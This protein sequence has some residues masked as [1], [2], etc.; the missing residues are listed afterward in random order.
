MSKTQDAVR[1]I[2]IWVGIASVLGCATSSE[3]KE[4]TKTERA[5]LF[6]DVA[7]ASLM[8]GDAIAALENLSRAESFAP[9]MPEI[10]HS[11]ALAFHMKKDSEAAIAAAKKAVEMSPKYS[12]AN[13]TLGKLL[14]D[15]SKYTEAEAP[16]LQASQ[17]PLNRE[18]YKA[19]TNLG[20]LYYRTD[21][22]EKAETFLSKAIDEVPQ[23]SC[24]A[25]YYRGHLRLKESRLKDAVKE[26]ERASN[27]M[28]G[29]FADAHFALGIAP[30]RSREYDRARKT[31]LSIPQNFP[32]SKVA[33]QA[34]ERLKHLP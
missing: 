11:R 3:R 27:K 12:A 9:E 1:G 10:S 5:R 4:L 20:I 13:N 29:A 34:M 21:R 32:E 7:N 17:D 18:A 6:L 16:L 26:Y 19:N 24:V 15:A 23:Q 22:I 31:F 8:E 2:W 30:E 25:Y 33:E 28:C 14:I